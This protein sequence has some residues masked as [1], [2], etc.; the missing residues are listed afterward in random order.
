MYERILLATDGSRES[1]VALR[2][3]ALLAQAYDAAVFLLV[4]DRETPGMRVSDAVSP[5]PRSEE[6]ARL[7]GLGLA[8]LSALGVRASGEVAYGEPA[9]TIGAYAKTFGADLVVV[10][11]RRQGLLDRWWSGASGAYL[12]EMVKCSVL[13]ARNVISDEEFDAQIAGA[14]KA[15]SATEL[16]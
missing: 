6:P 4:I 16:S 7:L 5:L 15:K 10:G 3:G 11:H 9:L 2:E 14:A 13:V 8:R 1:L 12:V